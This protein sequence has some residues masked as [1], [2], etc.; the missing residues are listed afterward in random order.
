VLESDYA[1]IGGNAEI[2][3]L[4]G[5]VIQALEITNR[6]TAI[7]FRGPKGLYLIR[8]YNHGQ[9]AVLKLVK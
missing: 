5:R 2:V 7:P 4:A 3:D 9:N 8:V 6:K 1:W